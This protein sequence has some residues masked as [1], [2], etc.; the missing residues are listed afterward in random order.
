ML[1]VTRHVDLERNARVLGTYPETPLSAGVLGRRQC[2]RAPRG[3]DAPPERFADRHLSTLK[4][5]LSK[6]QC[7]KADLKVK[8]SGSPGQGRQVVLPEDP[9]RGLQQM[10]NSA[11]F[12]WLR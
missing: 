10:G 4:L 3:E 12:S 11:D 5:Q 9:S 1:P 7:C 2:R 8:T 6:L